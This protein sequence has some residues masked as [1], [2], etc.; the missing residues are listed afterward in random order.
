MW[1]IAGVIDVGTKA[2]S[3]L[4]TYYLARKATIHAGDMVTT[5]KKRRS[6]V[7]NAGIRKSRSM[8]SMG[9]KTVRRT[10]G[11]WDPTTAST[12]A[13]AHQK[14]L[15]PIA[16]TSLNVVNSAA[17]QLL[18]GITAGD[19]Y[20]NRDGRRVIMDTLHLRGDFF[21]AGATAAHPADHVRVLVVYD[22]QPNGTAAI[23]GDLFTTASGDTFIN[24]NNLGRFEILWDKAWTL[25]QVPVNTTSP[26]YFPQINQMIR[27]KRGVQYSGTSSTIASIA[28][29][30]LYLVTIG[31][32]SSG[33]NNT[34]LSISARLTFRD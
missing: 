20:N 24:P 6:L 12:L 33:V 13:S 19:D 26:V 2:I 27:I 16:D 11:F 34:V 22:K 7:R 25:P 21:Y 17:V 1:N 15:D 4:A 29:G 31:S 8:G 3:G 23:Q 18:N 28:S 30:A 10:R 9:R 32:Q 5:Y 14:I